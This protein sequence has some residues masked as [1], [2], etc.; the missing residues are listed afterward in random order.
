MWNTNAAECWGGM[1]HIRRK[2]GLSAFFFKRLAHRLVTEFRHDLQFHHPFGQQPQCPT[3]PALRRPR[4]G[5]SQQLRLLRAVHLA[6]VNP[7]ARLG[8]QRRLQPVLDKALPHPPNRA[9]TDPHGFGNSGIR[10]VRAAFGRVRLQ[11]HTRVYQPARGC[12]A[13]RDHVT[14]RLSLLRRQRHPVPLPHCRLPPQYH[15]AEDRPQT[16]QSKDGRA[17]DGGGRITSANSISAALPANLPPPLAGEGRVGYSARNSAKPNQPR[18]ARIAA[19]TRSGVVGISICLTP[20]GASASSTA[21]TT[22]GRAPTV[23]ASPA[24]LA[25]NGLSL[26]GH[27]LLST[28]INAMSAARGIA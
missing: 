7:W 9:H 27:G 3:P 22:A 21:L 25:P 2:C 26:V 18:A 19:H 11:Q 28:F 6:C 14:E 5:Q 1:H 10:P 16:R 17:L 4:A 23:P 13:P 15:A 8:P 20:S 24:P 12:F